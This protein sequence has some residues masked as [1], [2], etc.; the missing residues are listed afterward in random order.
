MEKHDI[1]LKMVNDCSCSAEEIVCAQAMLTSCTRILLRKQDGH[2]TEV[3]QY[4]GVPL[5]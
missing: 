2:P 1:L 5:H 3:F 4:T